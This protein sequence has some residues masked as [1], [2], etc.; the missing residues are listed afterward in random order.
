MAMQRM[1]MESMQAN[2]G[3]A[4]PP[5]LSKSPKRA[6]GGQQKIDV[7]DPVSLS[8]ASKQAQG[9]QDTSGLSAFQLNS[10]IPNKYR[11][12]EGHPPEECKICLVDFSTND[13]VKML[14]C[15]HTFHVSCADTWLAKKSICPECQLNLRA[16]DFKQFY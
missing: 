4:P 8:S 16:L 5:L 14:Q 11:P 6:V 13:N 9:T 12:K 10:I 15:L 3:Q 2:A 7:F 1:L